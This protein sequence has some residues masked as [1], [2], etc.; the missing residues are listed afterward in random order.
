[1]IESDA[2]AIEEGREI[3][4]NALSNSAYHSLNSMHHFLN[5]NP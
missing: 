2:K 1:M 4:Q 5:A 3:Q